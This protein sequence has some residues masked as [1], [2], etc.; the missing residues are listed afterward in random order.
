MTSG[1]FQWVR[2]ATPGLLRLALLLPLASAPCAAADNIVVHAQR[3][4]AAVAIE[5]RALL[6][7]PLPVIWGTLTDY[8]R[9]SEFIPGMH[10]SRV[11]ERRGAIS[12][13]R[14]FGEAGLLLF[15]LPVDVVV[16]ALEIAP[17]VI[18]IRVLS[19]NLRKLDGRYQIEPDAQTP[20]HFVLRWFGVIEPQEP[21]PPLVGVPILRANIGE[22]FRGM[23]REIERRARLLPEPNKK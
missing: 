9:L 23:V 3:Q 6:A 20:G 19:G 4:G 16:E 1:P 8:D 10:A 2:F 5:A 21:I 18:E 15:R 17:H 14:Q 13:V 11:I 22:Q 7:A 12:V